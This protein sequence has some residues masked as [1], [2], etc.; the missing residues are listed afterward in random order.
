MNAQ[1]TKHALERLGQAKK[2]RLESLP[3][4]VKRDR[5]EDMVTLLRQGPVN[6]KLRPREEWAHYWSLADVIIWPWLEQ[7][8]AESEAYAAAQQAIR[9]EAERVKDAV[10]LGTAPEA[11][12][13]LRAF[14]EA[15]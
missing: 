1:Q 3:S 7:D 14:A 8:K 12:E 6:L 4:P 11:L 10:I 2:K 15:A 5:K 9:D 13:L